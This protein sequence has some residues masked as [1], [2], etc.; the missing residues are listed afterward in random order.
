MAL[1]IG[2]ALALAVGAFGTVVGLDRDRAFYTTT[3][4]VIASL[5]VLFAVMGASAQTLWIELVV[6]AVFIGVAT[7]GFKSSLWLVV[8]ALAGHGVFDFF[9]GDLYPNAG[10]PVWWPAFCGAYDIMAAAYLACLLARD[11]LRAA[12]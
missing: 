2:F 5:Y 7:W 3:M 1:F 8:I 10:V 4:I 9:H 12:A 11:R 6:A